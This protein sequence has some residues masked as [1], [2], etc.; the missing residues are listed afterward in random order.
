MIQGIVENRDGMA[1]DEQIQNLLHLTKYGMSRRSKATRNRSSTPTRSRSKKSG[2][3]ASPE[4][5]SIPNSNGHAM[6]A[7]DMRNLDPNGGQISAQGMSRNIS[8]APS[9]SGRHSRR[10]SQVTI[11]PNPE[12]FGEGENHQLDPILKA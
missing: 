5:K 7:H 10:E 2:I 9:R 8:A 12:I 1:Y 6:Q 4:F 3:L 11:N